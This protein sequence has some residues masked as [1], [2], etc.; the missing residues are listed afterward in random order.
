MSDL[1]VLT[2]RD[3][4]A[5]VRDALRERAVLILGV[6][7]TVRLQ[8]HR[9][10]DD[11]GHVPGRGGVD[12][13]RQLELATDLHAADP[14]RRPVGDVIAPDVGGTRDRDASSHGRGA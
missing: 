14:D 2:E 4:R 3:V 12:R 6:Q 1:L 8:E 10:L 13:L 9:R 7:F 11:V 5:L